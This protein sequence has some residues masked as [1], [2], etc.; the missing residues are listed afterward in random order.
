MNN[1]T[2]RRA[3]FKKLALAIPLAGAAGIIVSSCND[4]KNGTN[5][6][7]TDK[8]PADCHDLSGLTPDQMATRKNL[9]YVE[10]SPVKSKECKICALYIPPAEG[11]TCGT[12][13]LVPGP[14]E[15]LGTCTYFAPKTT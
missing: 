9:N 11:S 3:F 1:E 7:T 10:I 13:T 15:P 8:K 6:G 12:C 4:N 2:S 5:N 14:I